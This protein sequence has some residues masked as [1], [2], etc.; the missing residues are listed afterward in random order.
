M[1]CREGE[2]GTQTVLEEQN[3][4][5]RPILGYEEGGRGT[6]GRRLGQTEASDNRCGSTCIKS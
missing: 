4:L 3:P 5:P 1:R 2:G 6:Q